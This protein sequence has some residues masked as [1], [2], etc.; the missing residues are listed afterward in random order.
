MSSDARRGPD[1]TELLA[2]IV[3]SSQDAIV[4]KDLSSTVTSWNKSAERIFG[5]T[6]DEMVGAS[7]LTIVPEQ[8]VG[9]EAFILDQIKRGGRIEHF[10]T[11]RRH[12]SGRLLHVSLTISPIR[13]PSGE[14]VGAS[15][16]ARDISEKHDTDQ[17]IKLLMREVN[18]RVKNQFAVILSMLRETTKRARSPEEFERQ[19]RDRIMAL[20]RSHD[21]LVAADWRGALLNELAE[22]QVEPFAGGHAIEMQGPDIMLQPKAVQYLGMA[23]HELANN[24]ARYGALATR[25]GRVAIS[26]EI[27]SADKADGRLRLCWEETGRAEAVEVEQGGFGKVVIERVAPAAL[28]GAATFLLGE[29]GASWRIEAPM[30]FVA[31]G[32]EADLTD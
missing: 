30:S 11:M 3:D 4:S 21:L 24:S 13:S 19:V 25:R 29:D 16:I 27:D 10:E 26:W 8:R 14:I 5:Y 9:E 1:T 6:A 32:P 22:A 12:K 18:H 31:A 17:R 15:K 20:S 28:H 2:S 7:I 23:F